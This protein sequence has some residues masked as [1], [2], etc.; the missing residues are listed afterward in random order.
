MQ[1]S[2]L[3]QLQQQLQSA[4]AETRRQAVHQLGQLKDQR[5]VEVLIMALTGG[6][7]DLSVWYAVARALV[8]IGDTRAVPALVKALQQH[9][10]DFVRAEA[11]E[12]LGEIAGAQA[13]EVLARALQE[14]RG[15]GG[16]V[17]AA[18]AGA[19]G[20]IGDPRAVP[21]LSAALAGN[22]KF[23]VLC[24]VA[25]ALGKIGG[26]QAIEPLARVLNDIHTE[27]T[28]R[29]AAAKALGVIGGARAIGALEGALKDLTAPDHAGPDVWRQAAWALVEA[30][31]RTG[32]VEIFAQLSIEVGEQQGRI[33]ELRGSV[34]SIG[35]YR[36]N[37]I[38]LVDR[39]VARRH[40]RLIRLEDGTYGI[41][42]LHWPT[43]IMVNGRGLNASEIRPLQDGD[44]IQIGQTVLVFR[45]SRR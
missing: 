33:Y 10:D 21:A 9:E 20:N 27:S 12:I 40:A 42:D 13:V 14:D 11:A 25:E 38:I 39:L 43:G 3:E 8:A 36:N 22:D 2:T 32:A 7:R 31:R 5:A 35:R 6:E 34:V 41:E 19:L 30:R 18:A 44:R 4:N 15:V 45:S 29:Q 16:V 1:G 28:V 26:A 23:E 17:R 37:D 24:N